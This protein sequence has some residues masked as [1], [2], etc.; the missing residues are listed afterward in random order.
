MLQVG[1]SINWY[2]PR[3]T[4]CPELTVTCPVN[5]TLRPFGP[6]GTF[7]AIAPVSDTVPESAL[8]DPDIFPGVPVICPFDTF[9]VSEPDMFWPLDCGPLQ[10]PA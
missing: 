2:V 1:L 6:A 3:A 5:V 7:A 8:V 4:V 9:T 10:V